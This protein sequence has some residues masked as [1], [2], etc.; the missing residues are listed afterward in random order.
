MH[1]DSAIDALLEVSE[2]TEQLML[3]IDGIANRKDVITEA[4]GKTISHSESTALSAK[5]VVIA[6]ESYTLAMKGIEH[7]ISTLYKSSIKLN[8]HVSNFTLLE[9][10]E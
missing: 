6:I 9:K 8:N 10:D 7:Q 5:E 3:V 1:C 2:K 4:L